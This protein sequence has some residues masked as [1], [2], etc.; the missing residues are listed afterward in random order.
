MSLKN[1]KNSKPDDR[2][3]Q[4]KLKPVPHANDYSSVSLLDVVRMLVGIILLNVCVSWWF[5]G[6]VTYK[7]KG[8]L[9]QPHFWRYKLMGTPVLL[10]D[11][12]M[13]SYDGSDPSKPIYIAINGTVWDVSSNP[14]TYGPGGSYSVF[15]GKDCARAFA[16]NCLNHLTHDIRDIKSDERRRLQGWEDWFD[17]KYFRVGEVIH[18]ELTGEPLSRENCMG[19]YH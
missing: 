11:S 3:E 10:T 19:K 15:S 6:T 16:T 4:D 12:E 17:D 8:K 18:E 5:T 14:R 13:A 1:R 9:I 7:Y 2:K